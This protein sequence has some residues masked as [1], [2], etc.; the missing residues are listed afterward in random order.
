ME[1]LPRILIGLANFHTCL[2]ELGLD[3]LPGIK[4]HVGGTNGKGSTVNYLAAALMT[5]YKVAT[6]QTPELFERN[7]IIQINKIPMGSS[8]VFGAVQPL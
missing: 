1:N 4:I 6:F 5:N 7:D 3:I 8:F 2:Q